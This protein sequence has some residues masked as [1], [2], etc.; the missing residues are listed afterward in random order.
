MIRTLFLALLAVAAF[1]PVAS[2]KGV[3]VGKTIPSI[4][5]KDQNG[6]EQ[7]FDSLKGTKGLTIVFIRSVEWCP[8]CQRQVMDL[9]ENAA[10]FKDAGY[11]VVAISYDTVEKL[12]Q[13][14]QKFKTKVPMLSDARSDI[15]KAFGIFNDNYAKGTMAYGT[16]FPGVYVVSADKVVKAQFFKE[17]VQDRP[18]VDELLASM[19]EPVA[20]S[21]PA[22]EF[23]QE[24]T[25]VITETPAVIDAPAEDALAPA[26]E[27][28]PAPVA[29]TPAEPAVVTTPEAVAPVTPAPDA[30]DTTIIAPA[31]PVIEEAPATEF[32]PPTEDEAA[33]AEKV[34]ADT[35]AKTPAG[36]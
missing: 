10:K 33:P 6:K 19:K 30:A 20:V 2:A 7:S 28:A 4:T 14:Q 34:P 16:P 26:P 31:T 1:S 22:E 8:F 12:A 24:A 15:I 11:P 27:P 35:E 18:T 3:E 9:S 13:F 21:N 29:E 17:G 5:A 32:V 36:L 23:P 25:P